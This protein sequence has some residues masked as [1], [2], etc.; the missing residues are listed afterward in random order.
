M[1]IIE[2]YP[3]QE[4]RDK[5]AIMKDPPK[6]FPFCFMVMQQK[7]Y[8]IRLTTVFKEAQLRPVYKLYC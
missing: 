6:T 7:M 5:T 8:S 1:T 3:Q 2:D 4:I